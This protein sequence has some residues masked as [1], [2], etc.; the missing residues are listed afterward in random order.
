MLCHT[1]LV[2]WHF[3]PGEPIAMVRGSSMAAEKRS[4][5]SLYDESLI[6]SGCLLYKDQFKKMT[7]KNSESWERL[8][9]ENETM[10]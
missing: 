10:R 9:P 4:Q 2:Q 1:S 8:N 7:K 6:L 5:H 3:H